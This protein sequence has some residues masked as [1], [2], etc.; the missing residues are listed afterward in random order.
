[1]TFS[2]CSAW[3]RRPFHFGRAHFTTASARSSLVPGV[4]FPAPIR[5]VMTILIPGCHVRTCLIM[6]VSPELFVSAFSLPITWPR[7]APMFWL[8][9]R[10]TLR[11]HALHASFCW[12]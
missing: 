9:V 11:G 3:P 2:L 8:F 10:V 5:A 7:R 6:K 1:M 12:N 4:S